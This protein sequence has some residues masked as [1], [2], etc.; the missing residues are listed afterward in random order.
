ML[1]LIAGIAE[2]LGVAV[3]D[4]LAAY[5]HKVFVET[6]GWDIPDVEDGKEY[7]RFDRPDTLYIIAKDDRGFICGCARLLPTTETYLLKELSPEL[8]NGLPPPCS[9]EVWELSRFT[10]KAPDISAPLSKD[11][12]R[13]RF[14]VLFAAVVRTALDHGAIRLITFTAMG[15]ERILRAIGLHTHRVGPP[16]MIDGHPILALW[17]ELDHQTLAALGL[18]V[19]KIINVS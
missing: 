13:R 8:M 2:E 4:E 3:N 12:A 16:R 10:T 1:T 9:P 18:P 15:V 17:I 5:R 14:C 7:D 6:L 11:D 19:E